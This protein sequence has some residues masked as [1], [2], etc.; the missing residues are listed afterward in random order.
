MESCTLPITSL[1]Q[2]QVKTPNLGN[3]WMNP[4]YR[5]LLLYAKV[6]LASPKLAFAN[7][8][9]SFTNIGGRTASSLAAKHTNFK[10]R[11]AFRLDFGRELPEE[12][13]RFAL[14][15]WLNSLRCS[16]ATEVDQK[17]SWR[18]ICILLHLS[19]AV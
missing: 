5:E 8:V 3:R 15:P 17:N 4:L 11:V 12:R 6:M 9:L 16:A 2:K 18:R 7:A 14:F 13:A 19:G 10:V 1:K